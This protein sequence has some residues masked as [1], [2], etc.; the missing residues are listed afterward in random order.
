MGAFLSQ[1]LESAIQWRSLLHSQLSMDVL[2]KLAIKALAD[3][4]DNEKIEEWRTVG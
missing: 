2:L 4:N 1:N 3:L